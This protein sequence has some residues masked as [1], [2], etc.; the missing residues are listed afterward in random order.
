VPLCGANN[1]FPGITG[2]VAGVAENRDPTDIIINISHRV[3]TFYRCRL[4]QEA[5]KKSATRAFIQC[6]V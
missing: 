6:F 3:A 5:S 2:C 4:G 1:V